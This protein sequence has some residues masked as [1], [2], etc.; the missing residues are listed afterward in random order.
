MV[1][2]AA[3]GDRLSPDVIASGDES[4]IDADGGAA[5]VAPGVCNNTVSS[6]VEPIYTR[7]RVRPPQEVLTRLAC[8]AARLMPLLLISG[9][10]GG[11]DYDE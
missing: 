4:A 3:N 1:A 6:S 10:A 11:V 5:T 9:R 7:A 2:F 8:M